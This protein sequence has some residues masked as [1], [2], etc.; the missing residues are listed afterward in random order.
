M[1][2]AI[3]AEV[4]QEVKQGSRGVPLAG[5]GN[6]VRDMLQTNYIVVVATTKEQG[7]GEDVA[8]VLEAVSYWEYSAVRFSSATWRI[9]RGLCFFGSQTGIS[10]SGGCGLANFG[11]SA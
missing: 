5:R 9:L 2:P 3:C 4:R 1:A 6:P 7:R 10:H 11:R 8:W